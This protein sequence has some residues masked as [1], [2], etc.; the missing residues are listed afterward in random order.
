MP[1][2][3][4]GPT[5]AR[6]IEPG[7]E[8]QLFSIAFTGDGKTIINGMRFTASDLQTETGFEQSDVNFF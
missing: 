8:A 7:G 6:K 4:Q 2:G 1:D 3:T 5:N